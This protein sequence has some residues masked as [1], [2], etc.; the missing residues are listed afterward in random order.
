MKSAINKNAGDLTFFILYNINISLFNILKILNNIQFNRLGII[1][2]KL[3][4]I[5]II[6]KVLIQFNSRFK[7]IVEGSKMLNK[8]IIIFY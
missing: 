4:I 6:S 8:F 3:G 5:K 7:I 1:H 2:K